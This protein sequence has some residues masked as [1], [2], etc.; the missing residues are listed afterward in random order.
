MS[1]KNISSFEKGKAIVEMFS[2][3]ASGGTAVPQKDIQAELI[4]KYEAMP[5]I[6]KVKSL[7]DQL[8]EAYASKKE[9]E[10]EFKLEEGNRGFVVSSIGGENDDGEGDDGEGDDGEGDDG[11]GDDGEGDGGEGDGGEGDGGEGDGGEGDGGEGGGGEGGGG[12]GG[13][14]EGGGG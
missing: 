3:L 5:S 11:E 13:G 9:E 8:Q 14:G 6:V 2:L 7:E 1:K 4:R 12:E 10:L